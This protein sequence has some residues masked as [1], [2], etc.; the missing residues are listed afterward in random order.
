MSEELDPIAAVE[1][2]LITRLGHAFSI[3]GGKSA[4]KKIAALEVPFDGETEKHFRV[5]PPAVYVLPLKVEGGDALGHFTVHWAIYAASDR[6]TSQTRTEGGVGPF[7]IGS[8]A[9]AMTAARALQQWKPPVECA[10]SVEVVGVE[11]LTGLALVA[12][13]T[14]VWAVQ[15]KG[16]LYLEPETPAGDGQGLAP[17]TRFWS[18]LDIESFE[19]PPE[20]PLP[21]ARDAA[22]NVTLEGG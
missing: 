13:K 21:A 22:L 16:D 20:A 3:E 1:A 9:I 4:L 11:N 12:K 18:D 5:T 15:L 17:F 7:G 19:D 2:A 14:N 8:Y 6:A 10:S